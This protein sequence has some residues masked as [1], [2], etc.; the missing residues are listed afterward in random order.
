MLHRAAQLS[1]RTQVRAF[2]NCCADD[3][4]HGELPPL[5]KLQKLRLKYNLVGSSALTSS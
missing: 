2:G 4:R 5:L 3:V 1:F